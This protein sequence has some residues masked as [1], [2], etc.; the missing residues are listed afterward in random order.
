MPK[1]LREEVADYLRDDYSLEDQLLDALGFD[2]D[3]LHLDKA[4]EED[5]E[6]FFREENNSSSAV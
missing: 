4:T 6:I 1:L 5:I 3:A 2:S